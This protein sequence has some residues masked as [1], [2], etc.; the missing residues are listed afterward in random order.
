LGFGAVWDGQRVEA[1]NGENGCT[2]PPPAVSILN[3][4]KFT[5]F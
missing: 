2:L 5:Y 4:I 3:V 1:K